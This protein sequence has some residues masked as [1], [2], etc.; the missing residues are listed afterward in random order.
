MQRLHPRTVKEHA[1][2]D[3]KTKAISS[4]LAKACTVPLQFKKFPTLYMTLSPAG[5]GPWRFKEKKTSKATYT[6]KQ[7][8]EM[9]E[10]AEDEVV[11][12]VLF[13]RNTEYWG[14]TGNVESV[15]VVRYDSHD[16]VSL[17]LKWPV[18]VGCDL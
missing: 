13:E 1:L 10:L 8:N 15:K 14:P 4:G 7:P 12:H 17:V 6:E 2:M 3:R 5:T 18:F 11:E 16:E 9:C